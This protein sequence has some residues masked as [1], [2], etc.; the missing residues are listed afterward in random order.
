LAVVV[1]GLVAL[2]SGGS[3]AA[4]DALPA[5]TRFVI[6]DIGTA[7]PRYPTRGAMIGQACTATA[8]MRVADGWYAGTAHCGD[9]DVTFAQVHVEVAEL[10]A[11]AAGTDGSP[12]Q[13]ASLAAMPR[14]TTF[15]VR[16]LSEEDAYFP[17]ASEVIGLRCVA[18][19]EWTRASGP[20]WT[21]PALCGPDREDYY[22]LEVSFD[23]L[24]EL[25]EVLVAGR[26]LRIV[27]V[28]PDD[29]NYPLR[30][31]LIG[32]TCIPLEDL[33]QVDGRWYGGTVTCA[34]GTPYYF[35]EAAFEAVEADAAAAATSPDRYT[36]PALPKG[37]YVT[38]VDVFEGERLYPLRDYVIGARCKIRKKAGL[39]PT[40]DAVLDG[41]YGGSLKCGKAKV[42][43]WRVAIQP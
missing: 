14:G 8:A 1:G 12:P 38:I 25:P 26:P 42:D 5:G 21:G 32:L 24:G 37:S 31:H 15:L 34:D 33:A 11:A 4:A 35:Y 9:S 16:G 10:G 36:G 23:V 22:F 17:T 40:G 43:V 7:D 27:D 6:T 13:S 30:A 2:G 3:A 29:D 28:S 41:W 19:G 18:T 20:W 39:V